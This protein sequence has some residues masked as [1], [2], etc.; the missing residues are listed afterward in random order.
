MS[1]RRAV[2]SRGNPAF[3][4]RASGHI[5]RTREPPS[6]RSDMPEETPPPQQQTP[7]GETGAMAPEPRD[8]MRGWTGR[9]LLA[10]KVA[11]VTGGDSGIGRAVCAAFAKE[12]ADVAV[13]YLA[14]DTDAEHTAGLVEG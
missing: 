11:L 2:R 9:D 14:E 8:E 12:G 5:A 13:A 7:P 3:G 6:T 1:G 10:G 4:S